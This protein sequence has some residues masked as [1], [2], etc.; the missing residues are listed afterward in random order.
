M[1]ARRCGGPGVGGATRRDGVL[2]RPPVPPQRH[3]CPQLGEP[4]RR[5]TR[6]RR[7]GDGVGGVRPQRPAPPTA[8]ASGTVGRTEDGYPPPR[9]RPTTN[10]RRYTSHDATAT[11]RRRH[12]RGAGNCATS[13]HAP[14]TGRRRHPAGTPGQPPQHHPKPLDR[15]PP[16]RQERQPR[17]VGIVHTEPRHQLQ[18]RPALDTGHPATRHFPHSR[19]V[20][21]ADQTDTLVGDPQQ[22]CTT[23][24]VRQLRRHAADP[25]VHGSD[26]PH[27]LVTELPPDLPVA[28]EVQLHTLRALRRDDD[29]VGQE[30]LAG[31]EPGQRGPFV[32]RHEH[33]HRTAAAH[34]TRGNRA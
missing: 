6:V 18:P 8:S 15:A 28:M 10:R 17:A 12:E 26:V 5:G 4:R 1:V 30:L 22:Q 27:Q 11:G 33:D 3:D 14:A 25:T 29:T 16:H 2:L 32:K 7:E 13:H 21:R 34:D 20:T 19:T 24:G 23:P 31:R 9:P